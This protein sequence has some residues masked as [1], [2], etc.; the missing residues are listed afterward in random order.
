MK[1]AAQKE[2]N[3][4]NAAKRRREQPELVAAIRKR[5]WE[6]GGREKQRAR[7]AKKKQDDFFAYRVQFVRRYN[8]S[9]TPSDLREMWERQ[10]GLCGLT[11]R[12]LIPGDAQV[13]HILPQAR[14]GSHDLSNL[15]WVCRQ[16][17]QAKRD[18]TDAEFH[19]LCC[20]VAE[21]IGR[22]LAHAESPRVGV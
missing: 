17:N 19:E 9:A 18:L 11:G 8:P 2:A 21:W 10:K 20:T 6:N 16:A 5:A 14:G 12:P 3:R 15:R 13:D 4:L 1:T 7:T 22:R